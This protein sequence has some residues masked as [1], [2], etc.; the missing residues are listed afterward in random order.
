M[1]KTTCKHTYAYTY[2]D[3]YKHM[4]IKNLNKARRRKRRC[5][6]TLDIGIIMPHNMWCIRHKKQH[7]YNKYYKF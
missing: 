2:K 5:F 3:M 6:T 4:Y 1:Y 7:I